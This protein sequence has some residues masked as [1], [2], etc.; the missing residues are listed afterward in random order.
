LQ[1]DFGFDIGW[2]PDGRPLNTEKGG[3]ALLGAGIYPVSFASMIFSSQPSNISSTAHIGETGAG[4]QSSILGEYEGGRTAMLNGAVRL[5]L[6]NAAV[7]YGTKGHIHVPN[8][9]FG[10][11][12]T[13]H[14]AG[15][16]PVEFVDNREMKGYN[17]EAEEASNCLR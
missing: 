10:K 15:E 9:L 1:A 17:F 14:V 13:L 2:Q 11:S 6:N 16:E 8:F 5:R 7:I 12:A 4:E 3:G